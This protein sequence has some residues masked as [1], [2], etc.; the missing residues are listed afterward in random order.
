[1]AND[2]VII[3]ALEL[4][5]DAIVAAMRGVHDVRRH[6]RTF[7]VGQIGDYSVAVLCIHGMGNVKSA[8][9]ATTAIHEFE[10]TAIL[11]VGIAGGTKK[12][13]SEQF[14]K[15][16]HLLGDVLVAEQVL[17]YESGKQSPEELERRY[18][19]YRSSKTLLDSAKDIKSDWALNVKS[20]RPDHTTGRVVPTVHFGVFASGQKV[21]KD[22][23]LVDEL[24]D[25][26]AK[27]IG[28]EM[29]G[30]GVSLAAFESESR[31]HFLMAKAICDWADPDKD[32]NWQPYAA[33]ASATFVARLLLAQPFQAKQR[34]DAN[35]DAVTQDA[36]SGKGKVEFC[37]QLGTGWTELADVLEIPDFET[38]KFSKGEEGR[39]IWAYLSSRGRLGSLIDALGQID[40][41]DLKDVLLDHP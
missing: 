21:V 11:V 31:P 17:D 13:T 14:E 35:G 9:A 7:H 19:V 24:T 39:G 3:A 36:F 32:D 29:E 34:G 28:I 40:R 26:W 2:I 1:M 27:L 23:Q 20:L 33:E 37:R 25:D 30:L 4:E 15:G 12:P 5:R 22:P 41:S 6:G 16:S 38:A 8:A 10:P 18:E